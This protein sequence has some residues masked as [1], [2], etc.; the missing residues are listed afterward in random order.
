MSAIDHEY[1]LILAQQRVRQLGDDVGDEFEL[2]LDSTLEVEGGWV[3]FYNT[4]EYLRTRN[5][6]SALAGNGPIFVTREG[7]IS[8]LPSSIPWQKELKAPR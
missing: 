2:I 1:A 5:P 4:A 3:F 7:A 6:S 8:D